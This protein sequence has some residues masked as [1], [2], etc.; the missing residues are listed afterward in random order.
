MRLKRFGRR[1]QDG[2]SNPAE[3]GRGRYHQ[4]PVNRGV[5]K[6]TYEGLKKCMAKNIIS[7]V[8]T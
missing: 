5:E 1:S 3:A 2:G 8:I 4:K 7:A 6:K